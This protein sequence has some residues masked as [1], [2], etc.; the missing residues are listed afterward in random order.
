M[1]HIHLAE[2]P[3]TNTYLR[4]LISEES[5]LEPF[6]IVTAEDQT[7]GRGQKGN[8]WES[9]AG[10]NITL[11]MLIRPKLSPQMTTFDLSIIAALATQKIIVEAI[12]GSA[13]VKIKWPN[14][15]LIGERKIAGILIENEFSGSELE[16][17]IIGL[18]LNIAQE[19]FGTYRPEATSVAL[20]RRR[21]NLSPLPLDI[22][23]WHDLL[24]KRFVSEIEVMLDQ[25]STDLEGIRQEYHNHLYRKGIHGCHYRTAKGD[26]F[27]GTLQKVE[28]SGLLRITDDETQ[29]DYLFAFKEVQFSFPE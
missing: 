15:I 14:D 13:D 5:N 7:T 21:S 6:T 28:P 23:E 8:H 4:Q 22:R 12:E 29:E 27:T 2:V 9:D 1:R 17:C 10:K 19:Q 11:S 16:N 25:M 18:G 20:E 26:N 24:V 3:S